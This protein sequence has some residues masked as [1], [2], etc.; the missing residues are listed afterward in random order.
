MT[1]LRVLVLGGALAAL[2][3]FFLP[4]P[5]QPADP[6]DFEVETFA[7][8]LEIPWGMAF[9]PDG[10][11]LVTERPGR[12]VIVGSDGKVSAPIAGVPEVCACGQGG[13]LD[14]QLHPH[15]EKN[16][17][18]YLAYSDLKEG[19]SEEGFTAAMTFSTGVS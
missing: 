2:A 17:W 18:L 16:G 15:F 10:R 4:D 3:A 9:L 13:M 6:A 8:G 11:M 12:L 14:V 5:V 1:A 7:T 19:S